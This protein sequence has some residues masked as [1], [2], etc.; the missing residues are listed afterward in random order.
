MNEKYQEKLGRLIANTY[1]IKGHDHQRIGKLIET[2]YQLL[3][4]EEM[5]DLREQANQ[6]Q[7]GDEESERRIDIIGSNSNEGLHYD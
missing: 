5:R 7:W 4:Q 1:G 6:A 2:S 3:E